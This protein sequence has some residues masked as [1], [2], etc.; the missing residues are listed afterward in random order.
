MP[1]MT[2]YKE[3]EFCWVELATNDQPGAKSFYSSM[4]GWKPN[5]NPM[6]PDAFYTMLELKGKNAGALFNDTTLAQ[7]G[8]PPH[9]NIYIAVKDIDASAKKAVSLGGR[10]LMEPFDVMEHGRMAVVQDPDG[11]IFAMWQA[12]QHIGMGIRDEMNAFCWWEVSVNDVEKTKA[13]YTSL[14]GWTTKDSPEY[15]EWQLDGKSIGGCMKIQAEW[16]PMPPHWTAC[17]MVSDVDAIDKTANE[18]GGKT[19]VP[20]MDIPGTGRYSIFA[21][22]QGAALAVYA[23]QQK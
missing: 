20:P 8:V 17:V 19:L 23:Q 4:F 13:F 9:W 5:D 11:A 21:D 3:G 18:L 14:F 2:S 10:M 6:G 12:K 7:Q 1:D 15:T 16:G 22:P